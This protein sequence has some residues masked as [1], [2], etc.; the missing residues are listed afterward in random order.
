MESVE[1]EEE[2]RRKEEGGEVEV[3]KEEEEKQY[4]I[5]LTRQHGAI[6]ILE[7]LDAHT[8]QVVPIPEL[9]EV[10]CRD[11]TRSGCPVV[12]I[13]PITP[14]K[15]VLSRGTK[16][17]LYYEDTLIRTFAVSFSCIT[18]NEHKAFTMGATFS[19]PT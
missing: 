8:R 4:S 19:T 3:E 2:I 13:T 10:A 17:S 1:V 5:R 18:H 14:D 7:F 11:E 6:Y 12:A 15:Y 16:Y 9:V